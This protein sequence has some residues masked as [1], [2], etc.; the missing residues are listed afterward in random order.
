MARVRRQGTV[1]AAPAAEGQ[2]GKQLFLDKTSPSPGF[3]GRQP[4]ET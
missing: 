4:R 1:S 3:A 2:R